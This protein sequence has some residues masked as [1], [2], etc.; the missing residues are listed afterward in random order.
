MSDVSSVAM[1]AVA[2][3]EFLETQST[4]VLTLAKD[5]DGYGIPVSFAYD[6]GESSIYVRL[7]Y[8]PESQKREYVDAADRVS[9]VVYDQ[10]DDGWK[11]VV[12]RGELEEVAESSLQSYVGEA[13]RDL[14]IPFFTVFDRPASDI[15][16]KLTRL[17]IDELDGHAEL[18]EHM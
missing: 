5:D 15:E 12:A 6:A 7:G 4:G 17:A 9:F 3:D 11:S 14:D 1:D 16:F 13:M 8:A 2:I 18:S 10:T